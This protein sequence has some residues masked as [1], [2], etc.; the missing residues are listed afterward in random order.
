MKCFFHFVQA[1]W[2][3]LKKYKLANIDNIDEAKELSFNL[4]S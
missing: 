3:N 1:I 4:K 2:K